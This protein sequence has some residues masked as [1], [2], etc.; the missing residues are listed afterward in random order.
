MCVLLWLSVLCLRI[1]LV[2]K[3]S[4]DSVCACVYMLGIWIYG[5]LC[6]YLCPSFHVE[7]YVSADHCV[8][9]LDVCVYTVKDV[10]LVSLWTEYSKA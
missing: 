5:L 10:G 2:S 6:T 9:I 1:C 7:S 4:C 8:S 3:D